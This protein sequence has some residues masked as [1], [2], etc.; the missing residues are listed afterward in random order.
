[1]NKLPNE[2]TIKILNYLDYNELKI[3]NNIVNNSICD[4]V[5]KNKKNIIIKNKL[6]KVFDFFINKSIEENYNKKFSQEIYNILFDFFYKYIDE[7][8]FINDEKLFAFFLYEWMVFNKMYKIDSACKNIKE[9]IAKHRWNIDYIDK[10]DKLDDFYNFFCS[11]L[12]KNDF[13]KIIDYSK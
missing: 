13:N 4:Y 1:M 2:I 6:N 8:W 5:I 9:S 7:T 12:N 11:I 3:I 10:I